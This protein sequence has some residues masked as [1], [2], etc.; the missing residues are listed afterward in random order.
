MDG[1]LGAAGCSERKRL[2]ER[3]GE[4]GV[5]CCHVGCE[6]VRNDVSSEGRTVGWRKLGVPKANIRKGM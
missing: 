5:V 6:P 3:K 1:V 2:D 4:G